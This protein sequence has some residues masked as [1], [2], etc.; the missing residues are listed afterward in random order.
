MNRVTW[1]QS[2]L[3]DLEGI[4]DYIA[5]D[6]VY[7]AEKFVD[8]AFS[9]VGRL[10][11][12]PESGRIVPERNNQSIREVIYGSYRIIYKLVNRKVYI[13]TIVHS[14]RNYMPD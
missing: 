4:R 2:A 14:R 13:V 6:S 1:T 3:D 7:Y 8:G 9:A 12:S 10:E 11:K 5:R